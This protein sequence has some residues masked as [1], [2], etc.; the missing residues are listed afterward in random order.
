MEKYEEY[1]KTYN[2]DQLQD[3][4]NNYNDAVDVVENEEQEEEELKKSKRRP[5][6]RPT[7]SGNMG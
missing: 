7:R 2:N 3:M 5:T 1:D 6:K 4:I